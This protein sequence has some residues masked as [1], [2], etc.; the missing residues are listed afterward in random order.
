MEP[1]Y[2]VRGD[3]IELVIQGVLRGP[4]EGEGVLVG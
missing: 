4:R 3:L 1:L 2:N